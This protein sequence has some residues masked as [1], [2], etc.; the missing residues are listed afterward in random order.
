MRG[1]GE[2]G[3]QGGPCLPPSTETGWGGE[4][5]GALHLVGPQERTPAPCDIRGSVAGR[6]TLHS[7]PAVLCVCKALPQGTSA[8]CA[9]GSAGITSPPLGS[10]ASFSTLEGTTGLM[11]R[12]AVPLLP[13]RAPAWRVEVGGPGTIP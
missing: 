4:R 1:G 12:A 8:A 7:F 2:E 10:G 5:G 3:L 13:S 6:G 11:P 9:L